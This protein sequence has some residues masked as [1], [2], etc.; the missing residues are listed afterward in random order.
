[1]DNSYY[2]SIASGLS[3]YLLLNAHSLSHCGLAKGKAGVALALGL[4]GKYN[5]DEYIQDQSIDILEEALLYKGK[6]LSFDDGWAGICWTVLTML[7]EGCLDVDY[8]ELLGEQH[9][10]IER[11][12]QRLGAEQRFS[13]LRQLGLIRMISEYQ[14]LLKPSVPYTLVVN[15]LELLESRILSILDAWL[16]SPADK[17][18]KVARASDIVELLVQYLEYCYRFTYSPNRR[19]LSQY[20]ACYHTGQI[21]SDVRLGL[22]LEGVRADDNTVAEQNLLFGVKQL[23]RPTTLRTILDALWVLRASKKTK[24]RQSLILS[25]EERIGISQKFDESKLI[26]HLPMGEQ[27]VGYAS[28]IARLVLYLLMWRK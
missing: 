6:D 23:Q 24:E 27:R 15:S 8:I 14:L 5:Q 12:L 7:K 3:D 17:R 25:I 18:V 20:E 26:K 11:A 10:A 22:L 21:S 9:L 1:M 13:P 19:V 4:L 16:S 2:Q 28:G